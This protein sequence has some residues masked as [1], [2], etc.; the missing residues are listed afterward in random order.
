MS[1]ES[2]T[3]RVLRSLRA[4]GK[5]VMVRDIAADLGFDVENT[6]LHPI[7]QVLNHLSRYETGVRRAGN[8]G[9]FRYY[10]AASDI[11]AQIRKRGDAA[12]ES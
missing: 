12:G 10:E 7:R 8:L 2:L 6:D 9:S 5:P 4:A 3:L 1:Q 11:D